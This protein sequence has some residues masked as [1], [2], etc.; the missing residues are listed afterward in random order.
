MHY[1]SVVW[2]GSI[3]FHAPKMHI[4]YIVGTAVM[5]YVADA[6]YGMYAS[7]YYVRSSRFVRLENAVELT[8]A[9]PPGFES[10]GSGFVYI[11]LPRD[12]PR[13][14]PDQPHLGLS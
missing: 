3:A 7:T 4:A 11:C 8:F 12:I 13:D 14:A 9:H 6:L 1:L 10:N 5:L 2:G